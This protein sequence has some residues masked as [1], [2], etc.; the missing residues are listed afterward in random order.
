[1]PSNTRKECIKCHKRCA[2]LLFEKKRCEKTYRNIC[3]ACRKSEAK[4]LRDVKRRFKHLQPA[5]A[6][7]ICG[8]KSKL[9]FDHDHE[10]MVFRG[11]LCAR[12]NRSLGAL[13][14]NLESL[15]RVMRY[16][17]RHE[18]RMTQ[19]PTELDS[20]DKAILPNSINTVKNVSKPLPINKAICTAAVDATYA[21]YP[22]TN[23]LIGK[24][25]AV[26]Q[27]QSNMCGSGVLGTS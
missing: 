17:E 9:V 6:C 14:D 11:W 19:P 20:I 26:I 18:E 12:C 7:Q 1:M 15:Q 16:L 8:A 3:R 2:I 4:K 21:A 23:A 22:H 13:G 10:R 25:S 24:F 5:G 27:K